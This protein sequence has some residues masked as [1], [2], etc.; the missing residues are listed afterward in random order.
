[1]CVNVD[2]GLG[3]ILGCAGSCRCEES[4]HRVG[5]FALEL[6]LHRFVFR[7]GRFNRWVV[8]RAG[9]IVG[10]RLGDGLARSCCFS[11]FHQ[12]FF[13]QSFSFFDLVKDPVFIG[14]QVWDP[15]VLLESRSP[16]RILGGE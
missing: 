3:L 4:F 13:F 14:K 2:G 1:M 16:F 12:L 6:R 7:D 8:A 10:I 15:G 5:R 11:F 9:R